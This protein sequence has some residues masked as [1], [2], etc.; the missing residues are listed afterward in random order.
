MKDTQTCSSISKNLGVFINYLDGYIIVMSQK[1]N[2]LNFIA[3]TSMLVP[4]TKFGN[5][6]IHIYLFVKGSMYEGNLA[7]LL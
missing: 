6:A 2:H 5:L 4:H 1:L 3:N 7:I